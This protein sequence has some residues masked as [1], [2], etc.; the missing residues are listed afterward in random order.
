MWQLMPVTPVLE[1]QGQQ[2]QKFRVKDLQL[3]RKFKASLADMRQSKRNPLKQTRNNSSGAMLPLVR[4]EL[5]TTMDR[6]LF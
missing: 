4:H 6:I 2:S 1:R 3:H 5:D